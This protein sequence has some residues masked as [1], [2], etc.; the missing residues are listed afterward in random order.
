MLTRDGYVLVFFH[1]IIVGCGKR[2]NVVMIGE[3][4]I[5]AKLNQSF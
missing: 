2:R 5:R 1:V 3:G 4:Q